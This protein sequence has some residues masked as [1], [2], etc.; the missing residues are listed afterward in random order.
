MKK[1]LSILLAVALLFS[2]CGAGRSLSERAIVKTIYLDASGQGYQAALVVFTCQPVADT[3]SV[4]EQAEIFTGSGESIEEALADAEQ[5]QNKQAFYAQ[6]ELLLLGPGIW[7]RD[8][9]PPLAYFQQEKA[10]RAGLSVFLTPVDGKTFAEC[11][12]TIADTVRE[13]ERIVADSMAGN[14]PARGIY[15]LKQPE[16][17]AEGWLPVLDLGPD[18]ETRIGVFRLALVERGR[19]ASLIEGPMMDL[20]MLLSGNAGRLQYQSP[21]LTFATQHLRSRKTL[22]NGKLVVRLEGNVQEVT[23]RGENV[24]T[25]EAMAMVNETLGLLLTQLGRVTL[26]EGND[27]FQL[28]WWM[29]QQDAE[30]PPVPVRYESALQMLRQ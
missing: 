20:A 7:S 18:K 24:K 4:E 15:A 19:A 5:Q 27:A 1:R 16:G 6:N 11:T 2:G 8:I 25:D 28:R 26:G 23:L 13:G 29:R 21:A 10:A 12:D 30:A 22:E 3:K 17:K 9:T 14:G